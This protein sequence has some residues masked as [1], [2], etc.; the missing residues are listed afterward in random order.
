MTDIVI[1][2]YGDGKN[3]RFIVWIDGEAHACHDESDLLEELVK[4]G[5]SKEHGQACIERLK[6][7]KKPT[8]MRV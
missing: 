2:S 5:A 7:A 8:S 1:S 6:E 3:R 4:L